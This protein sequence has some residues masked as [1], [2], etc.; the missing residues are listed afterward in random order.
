MST[1]LVLHKAHE[2]SGWRFAAGLIADALVRSLPLA[3]TSGPVNLGNI[4]S[5]DFALNV[6]CYGNMFSHT[7]MCMPCPAVAILL[8]LA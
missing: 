3:T 8:L 6:W 7:L 1:T 5:P 2:K 4:P